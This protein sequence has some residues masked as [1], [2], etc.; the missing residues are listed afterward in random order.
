MT[1]TAHVARNAAHNA[2]SRALDA[3]VDAARDRDAA[4][5]APSAGDAETYA[6]RAH[7]AALVANEAAGRARYNADIAAREYDRWSAIAA[8]AIADDATNAQLD[9]ATVEQAWID[10]TRSATTAEMDAE[11]AQH[12]AARAQATANARIAAEAAATKHAAL[13]A[14]NDATEAAI[15][16]GHAER[17]TAAA[18]MDMANAPDTA[19]VD[20][21]ERANLL[22]L[23]ANSHRDA[24]NAH[25]AALLREQDA[26][27]D[28]RRL[29][30]DLSP[31]TLSYVA[32]LVNRGII[33]R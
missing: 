18:L 15:A 19:F 21:K 16:T 29:D 9:A 6:A 5:S 25:A 2:A 30:A 17:E 3:A 20:A 11:L 1:S 28:A 31:D 24:T 13:A 26:W 10:A 27:D 7:A 23:Y 22:V 14:A 33:G 8:N 12:H 32:A 4:A